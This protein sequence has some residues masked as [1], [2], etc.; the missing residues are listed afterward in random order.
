MGCSSLKRPE[1]HPRSRKPTYIDRLLAAARLSEDGPDG[2][3]MDR[4]E[5]LYR[6]LFPVYFAVHP[7]RRQSDR[8]HSEVAGWGRR[9]W[10]LK[11]S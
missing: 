5:Q 1:F 7:S 4:I 9:F 3:P 2:R 11:C 6:I 8:W 10:P